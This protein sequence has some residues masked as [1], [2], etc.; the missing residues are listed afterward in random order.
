MT[1]S[2]TMCPFCERYRGMLECE[3]FPEG[4]IPGEILQG[5]DHREPFP[6]DH[7]IRFERTPDAPPSFPDESREDGA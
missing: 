2:V 6:G 7:G 3:A 4:L 1:L 5:F